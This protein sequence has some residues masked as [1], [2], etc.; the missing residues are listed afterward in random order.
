MATNSINYD[1]LA[2][3]NSLT[4]PNP[5]GYSRGGPVWGTGPLSSA[6]RYVMELGEEERARVSIFVGAEANVGKTALDRSDIEAIWQRPDFPR[7]S[8]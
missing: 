2:S 3:V 8:S 1:A 5:A 7:A 4:S 6:V